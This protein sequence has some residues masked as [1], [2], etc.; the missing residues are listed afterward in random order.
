MT[1]MID[2][3][4]TSSRDDLLDRAVA[5]F[6]QEGATAL[7]LFGSLA[8]GD[9]D[10][11]S[12]I[13]LWITVPDEL[14][15]DLV[16]RRSV[17]YAAVGEVFIEHEAPR[18]RPVGGAY[19]LVLHRASGSVIQVDYYLAPEST[20][21]VLP[22]ARWLAG[23]DRLPRGAWVLDSTAAVVEDRDERVDF[24]ICMSFIGVK[25]ALRGDRPF[26]AFL[27]EQFER[28]SDDYTRIPQP[29]GD[30]AL[31]ARIEQRLLSLAASASTRQ[32]TA[33]DAVVGYIDG[34]R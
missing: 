21:V 3:S 31:L 6:L 29:A 1:D 23:S 9:G 17:V 13:D 14:I 4:E 2:S 25:K 16:A 5:L 8:R 10:A 33:I 28:F 32:R 24:L 15:D 11:L 26:L 12:D 30:V 19:T 22:E 27:D 34:H 20:S 18:N 7:H